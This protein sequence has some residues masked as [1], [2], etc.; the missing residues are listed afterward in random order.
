MGSRRAWAAV[1]L[2]TFVGMINMIDR[3]LP[4]VLIEQIKHDLH[5]SDTALGL[6]NGFGFL[7]V[8][9]LMGIPMARLADRGSYGAVVAGCVA[10]WSLM[11][12]LGAFARDGVQLALTRMGVAVGEAGSLPAAHAFVARNF[13]PSRRAAPISVLALAVPLAVLVGYL[14]AGQAGE[15]FGWRMTFAGM[16]VIGL[17]VAPLVLVVLGRSQPPPDGDAPMR[18][19]PLAGFGLLAMRSFLL[20]VIAS[21]FIGIGGYAQS[22]FS[23]AFLM[24][25]H[26]LPLGEVSMAYGL[27]SGLI[28]IVGVLGAGVLADRLSRRDA[29]WSLWLVVCLVALF[30]P[31][32]VAALL[33]GHAATSVVLLALSGLIGAAYLPPV[34]A[35]IQRLVP[36]DMRATASAVLMLFTALA[37]GLG[38][39]MVGMASDALAPSL[40]DHALG[41]ALLLVPVTQV[42]AGVFYLLAARHLEGDIAGAE[43][44]PG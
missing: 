24:R 19:T 5:L 23:I 14:A 13:A 10:L 41:R 11:T 1:A 6:I 38:P 29:R 44:Q 30:V 28:N 21:A 12:L 3:T 35:A 37:G 8:Y 25:S 22:A 31:C 39:L 27:A 43:E 32:T 7:L 18:R 4:S 17:V 26:G 34:V 9:A 33:V 15:A 36:A 16:G 2:L 42:L 20:I 40:G